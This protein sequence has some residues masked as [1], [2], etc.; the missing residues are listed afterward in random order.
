MVLAWEMKRL[1]KIYLNGYPKT[2]RFKSRLI[3]RKN[4]SK[5]SQ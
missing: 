3:K 1:P 2:L 5:H 4:L